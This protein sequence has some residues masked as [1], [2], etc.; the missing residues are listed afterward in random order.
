[1]QKNIRLIKIVIHSNTIAEIVKVVIQ[2]IVFGIIL[3][4]K[5]RV[6]TTTGLKEYRSYLKN[7]EPF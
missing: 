7:I 2:N 5:K 1:M 4:I 6:E 3:N